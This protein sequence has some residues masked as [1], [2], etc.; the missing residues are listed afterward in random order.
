MDRRCTAPKER[1]SM[2]CRKEMEKE[3]EMEAS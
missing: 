2:K 1:R 3:M